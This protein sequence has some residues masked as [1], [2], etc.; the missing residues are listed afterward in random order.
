MMPVPYPD[1]RHAEVLAEIERQRLHE[2]ALGEPPPPLNSVACVCLTIGEE[3][4]RLH[5]R[6]SLVDLAAWALRGIA[7]HDGEQP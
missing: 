3:V 7:L 2:L 4:G 1:R 6:A 5:D